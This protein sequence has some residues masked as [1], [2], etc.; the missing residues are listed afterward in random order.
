MTITIATVATPVA[1]M[2]FVF[3]MIYAAI[4]DIMTYRIANILVLT[5]LVAYAGLA[6]VVGFTHQE[7]FRS[8]AAAGAVLLFSFALFAL[9]LVGGG[10]AK[11]TTVTTLWL[12]AENT[13]AYLLFLTLLGGMLAGFFYLCHTLPLPQRVAKTAWITRLRAK[14]G[15]KLPYG[16]AITLAGLCVLPSSPWMM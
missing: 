12:G 7:I 2:L 15:V 13:V 1:L 5:L 10:D 11:L 9:G 4:S 16:V 8:V 3:A 6:P 14:N